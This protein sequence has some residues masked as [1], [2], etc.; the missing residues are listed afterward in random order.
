MDE[1]ASTQEMLANVV[2]KSRSSIA[3]SLRLLTLPEFVQDLVDS[4]GLQAGHARALVG[5]KEAE[6]L[7]KEILDKGLSVRQAELLT[8]DPSQGTKNILKKKSKD[9]DTIALENDLS[10]MLGLKVSIT[11]NGD[12]AKGGLISFRYSSLDQLD[13]ILQRLNK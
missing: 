12:E 13:D 9:P 10:L 3:N 5:N 1:F 7:A 11:F 8:K 4:G 6:K 2:G